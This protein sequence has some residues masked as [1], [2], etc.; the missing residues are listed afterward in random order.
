MNSRLVA[1]SDERMDL[2]GKQVDSG[3]QAERAMK[4]VLEVHKCRR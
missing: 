2:A 3:Q 4:F 1:I